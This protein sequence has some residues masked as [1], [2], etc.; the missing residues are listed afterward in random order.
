V[1]LAHPDDP[2]FFCGGTI[3]RWVS[4]GREVHYC[5]LTRGDKGADE[6]GHNSAELASTRE[7]EQRAAAKVLGVKQVIFLPYEDGYL[8]PDLGLRKEV[9]RVIRQ[10]RPDIVVTCDPTNFF[11]GAN[12]INHSDHRV[13]GQV[14]LDAVF[15][16]ARSALY[17]PDLYEQEGLEPHKVQQV[18]ISNAVQPDTT[19]D[20]TDYLS[21]KLE[22]LKAHQSQIQDFVSLQV[23][24]KERMLDPESPPA[25]PCYVERFKKITLR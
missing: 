20:V 11:P 16:A 24:L 22:A 25:A 13:A 7:A 19:I 21:L 17:F 15:P 6:P 10:V 14:T 18:Y 3:A 9:V 1:V 23:R 8:M 12:Y 4:E 5:L 2:D